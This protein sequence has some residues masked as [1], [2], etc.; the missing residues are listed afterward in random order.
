[1][2]PEELGPAEPTVLP[3]G[4][5]HELVGNSGFIQCP[6]QANGMVVGNHPVGIP[7]DGQHRRQSR[8]DVAQRR[9]PPGDFMAVAL[10]AQPGHGVGLHVLAFQQVIDVGDPEPVHDGSHLEVVPAQTAPVQTRGSRQHPGDQGKMATRRPSGEHD[11][12][13]VEVVFL[14]VLHDPA[15]GAAG[16]L[17]GTRR[18]RDPGQPV[19]HV[20]HGPAHL[21]IG[22]EM[23]RADTLVARDPAPA[24][25]VDHRGRRRGRPPRPVDIQ[26]GLPVVGHQVGDVGPDAVATEQGGHPAFRWR[27]FFPTPGLWSKRQQKRQRQYTPELIATQHL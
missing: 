24:V 2:N 18:Q 3:A 10:A 5:G 15:Q 19:S 23:E 21:Q 13:G 8:P 17:D 11:L 16:V 1:M 4:N 6:M 20:D 12:V 27:D 9:D 26:L 25:N 7:V 22:Q 14:G